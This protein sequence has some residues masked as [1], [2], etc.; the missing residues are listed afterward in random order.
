MVMTACSGENFTALLIR[1]SNISF[2]H[3]RSPWTRQRG[4][5]ARSSFCPLLLH[6]VG[7][8]VGRQHDQFPDIDGLQFQL[9]IARFDARDFQHLID[10]GQHALRGQGNFFRPHD[11]ALKFP[12]L[13]PDQLGRTH[14][15]LQRIF[16]IVDR[17]ALHFILHAVGLEQLLVDPG[18]FR[19][20]F[21]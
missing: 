9:D 1:L 4:S 14:D 10:Q 18:K 16:Q 7:E 19:R 15:G 17:D 21:P 5:M 3:S 2:S 12:V 8:P 13:A 6:L 20:S 11:A